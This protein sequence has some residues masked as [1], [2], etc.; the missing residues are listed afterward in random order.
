MII[1]SKTI[2]P[3]I[4]AIP[5]YTLPMFYLLLE[6]QALRQQILVLRRANPKPAFSVWDKS[7]WVI[8]CR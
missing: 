5:T 1:P 6:I 7:F 3:N 2:W 4:S 8:L